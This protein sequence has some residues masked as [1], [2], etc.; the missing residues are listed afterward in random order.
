MFFALSYFHINF[1]SLNKGV[2]VNSAP[3]PKRRC[4]CFD[5]KGGS[6]ILNSHN[7]T[8]VAAA[9]LVIALKRPCA[10]IVTASPPLAQPYMFLPQLRPGRSATRPGS[11]QCARDGGHRPCAACDSPERGRAAMPRCTYLEGTMDE[12]PGVTGPRVLPAY[13]RERASEGGV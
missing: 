5:R 10:V 7:G 8:V 13:G 12:W 6:H 9:R 4:T 1:V 3:R 11:S 2:A